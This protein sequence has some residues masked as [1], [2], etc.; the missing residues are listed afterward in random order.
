MVANITKISQKMKKKKLVEYR[1]KYYR[2]TKT[3]FYK[4][5]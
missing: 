4:K 5:Q 3:P 1:K 2:I